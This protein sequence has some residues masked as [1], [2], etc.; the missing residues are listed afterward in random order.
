MFKISLSVPNQPCLSLLITACVSLSFGLLA[1]SGA[2]GVDGALSKVLGFYQLNTEANLA[3]LRPLTLLLFSLLA[4]LPWLAFFKP[5]YSGVLA[6]LLLITALPPLVSLAGSIHWIDSLGGFPAIGSGQG[7]IK[8]A[9][10]VALAGYWL[11]PFHQWQ[12]WLNYAPVALVLLW[13]GGMKFTAIEAQG[14]EDLVQSSPLLN[15]L[16]L[17]FDV[18]T[19]SNLIGVYD[20]VALSLLGIGL[21]YKPLFWPGWLMCLA[22]FLTTQSFLVT[23]A[24]AFSGPAVLTGSGQFLIKDLWFMA[25]LLVLLRWQLHQSARPA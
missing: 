8:Y 18:Q 6:L 22:V 16:Y 2:A 9:A 14:I 5:G 12:H 3:L 15:W 1:L 13:I 10:L 23:F 21:K 11:R 25:N 7:I 19:T 17:L 20:L 4:L 24:G